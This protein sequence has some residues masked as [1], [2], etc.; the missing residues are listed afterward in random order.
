MPNPR[1]EL[2]ATSETYH[3]YNRSIAG[4]EIF[5]NKRNLFRVLELMNYYRFPQ[6]LKYS[7]FKLLPIELRNQRLKQVEY[8]LPLVEI[9]AFALMP[10]HHH[11]LMKQLSDGGI[12]KFMSN[13]QNGFAKYFNTKTK[14]DGGLFQRPFKAKR[15]TSDEIFIHVSRYIHLNPVTSFLTNITQLTNDD[16]TSYPY[17]LEHNRGNLVNTKELIKLAGTVKRYQEFV[18]DQVNYQNRLHLIKDFLLEQEAL[19]SKK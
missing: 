13:F 9:Y 7:A 14:R 17:Y 11:F 2:L 5:T 19:K 18:N 1:K 3:V 10:N 15:V 12:S 8:S 4:Q 16:R 6:K